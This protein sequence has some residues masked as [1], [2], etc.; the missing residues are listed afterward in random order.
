MMEF[1]FR[2]LIDDCSIFRIF[3]ALRKSFID[4]VFSDFNALKFFNDRDNDFSLS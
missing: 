3:D 4:M 1:L 2:D